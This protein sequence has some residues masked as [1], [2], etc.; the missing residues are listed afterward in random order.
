MNK[1]YS[2]LMPIPGTS[3]EYCRICKISHYFKNNISLLLAL[4]IGKFTYIQLYKLALKNNIITL[5]CSLL[6]MHTNSK[7]DIGV[8]VIIQR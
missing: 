1:L 7:I 6:L 4:K 5:T 8:R 2:L 3:A